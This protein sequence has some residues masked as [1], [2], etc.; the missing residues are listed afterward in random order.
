[1]TLQDRLDTIQNNYE[2]SDSQLTSK[3]GITMGELVEFRARRK[4]ASYTESLI[5]NFIT[6][7]EADVYPTNLLSS[8]YRLL[9]RTF[10]DEV[11]TVIGSVSGAGK[12]HASEMF[13]HE[14]IGAIYVYVPEIISPRYLLAILSVKLGLPYA[15]MNLQQMY[16]GICGELSKEKKLFVFDEADRL[17]K[18]MFEILRDIW[19]DGK[20]NCGLAFVGDENMMNKIR[21]GQTLRENLNRL[22]RRI[23]YMEIF[24]PIHADD[25]A[26]VFKHKLGRTKIT[27]KAMTHIYNE[28]RQQ[29]GLGTIID[30][31]DIIRRIAERSGDTP[32]NEMASEALR[33]IKKKF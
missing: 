7:L 26:I 19:H 1:M 15:G 5:T 6:K 14:N 13:C 12:T 24:D 3:I 33:R 8:M 18:K 11:I 25:V 16:E 17:N 4:V 28:C 21:R 30:L 2:F 29:G 22:M 23:K 9:E 10:K 27:E 20:G 32:D 31:A